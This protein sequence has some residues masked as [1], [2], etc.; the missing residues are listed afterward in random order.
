[1]SKIVPKPKAL[2][3]PNC[4]SQI[5]LRAMGAAASVVCAYCNTTLDATNPQLTIL[6]KFESRMKVEPVIPLGTRGTLKGSVWEA[7]GF[8]QRGINVDGT[9]YFWREYVLFNPYKGFRYLSEYENH[10]NFIT[11]IPSRPVTGNSAVNRGTA[12]FGG[13][14]YHHFQTAQAYTWFVIG[15]FPWQVKTG[16]GVQSM[17]YVA[18]PKMLSA[19]MTQNEVTWSQGEYVTGQEIWTAFK[20]PGTPP[21]PNGIFANQPAPAVTGPGR[22]WLVFLALATLLFGM[23]IFFAANSRKEQVLRQHFTFQPAAAGEKSL[24]TPVFEL[25]GGT[26]N[27]QIDLDT[28]MSNRWAYF[29][30]ALINEQTGDAIDFGREVS[31]YAGVDDGE[32]W[33]EGDKHEDF[34]IPG[35][36]GGRY[37][38]RIEPETDPPAPGV[39]ALTSSPINYRVTVTRDVPFYFRYLLGILLLFIPV[40]FMGRKGGNFEQTRWME[41]DHGTPPGWPSQAGQSDSGDEDDE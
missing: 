33:S 1:V 17:D 14:E 32:S 26:G 3:C 10:W 41:S 29:A 30:M 40:L 11:S 28:E 8:Q 23:M 34:I 24:V 15:E 35:V 27:V 22:P 9:N 39:S 25:K 20:L 19:E 2:N 6:Q 16:E 7:I 37:Y 4:G 5:E 36:A 38:L 31:Y 13:T 21:A 12:S 18:A